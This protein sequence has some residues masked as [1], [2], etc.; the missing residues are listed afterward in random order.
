LSEVETSKTAVKSVIRFL[1]RNGFTCSDVSIFKKEGEKGYD[2]VAVNGDHTF[3]IEIKGS[4]H[5]YGIPDSYRGEFDEKVKLIADLLWIVRLDKKANRAIRFEVLTKAEVDSFEHS[6]V[7]R[8]RV[9]KLQT[10]LKN[11]KVGRILSPRSLVS[12]SL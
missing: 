6:I 9:N 8:V 3:R 12:F 5:D 4:Y 7:T 1:T 11:R 10:A 2:V